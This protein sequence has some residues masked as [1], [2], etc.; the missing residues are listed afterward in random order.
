MWLVITR[1]SLPAASP[2]VI[3]SLEDF[4][5]GTLLFQLQLQQYCTG[6]TYE[7]SEQ[8]Q[9]TIEIT[10]PRTDTHF[11]THLVVKG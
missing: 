8:D 2:P 3:L 5:S 4:M 6:C 7:L 11:F 1:G 9:S 10:V